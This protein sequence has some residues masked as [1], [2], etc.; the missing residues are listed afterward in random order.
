M[1]TVAHGKRV[2]ATGSVTAAASE[3]ATATAT[4]YVFAGVRL[5]LGWTFLWAF[6][7]R[8]WRPPRG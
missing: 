8:L 3:T 2:I 6:L 1:A 5:A 7:G 4:P